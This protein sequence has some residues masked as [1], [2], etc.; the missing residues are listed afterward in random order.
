EWFDRVLVLDRKVLALGTP[1]HVRDCGVYASIR[2]HAHTHGHLRTD[3][4][5]HEGHAAHPEI[6]T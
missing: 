1:E 3:H 6:H 2:E 4:E 5:V